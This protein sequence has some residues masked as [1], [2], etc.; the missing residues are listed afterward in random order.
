M[1]AADMPPAT[2]CCASL[3]AGLRRWFVL[4]IRWDVTGEK[5]SSSSLR[6]AA[7]RTPGNWRSACDVHAHAL[8]QFPGV[9]Q[10]A[11]RSDDEEFFSPVTSHRIVRTNHRRNPA[12]N[13]AQHGVAGGMS[14]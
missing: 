8:R 2:P 12:G 6:T 13:D 10:A 14:A 4:T 9:R 5:N 7:W 1:T 3:P 11:V